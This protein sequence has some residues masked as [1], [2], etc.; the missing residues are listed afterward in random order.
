MCCSICGSLNIPPVSC[1]SFLGVYGVPHGASHPGRQLSPSPGDTAGP[2]LHL[3]QRPGSPSVT[4][5]RGLPHWQ[6]AHRP[7]HTVS[8]P[9]TSS[10]LATPAPAAVRAFPVCTSAR[11][12]G[13]YPVASRTVPHGH[14]EVP[15]PS[16]LGL[17]PPDTPRLRV[18]PG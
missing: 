3:Q 6:R 14:R 13:T 4:N 17:H 5:P 1:P 18:H 16:S 15:G 10:S 12:M 11:G 2:H 7:C 8:F 9:Y